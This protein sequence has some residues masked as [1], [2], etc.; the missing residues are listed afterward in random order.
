M[1]AST[2]DR[3]VDQ[4]GLSTIERQHRRGFRQFVV[5]WG[6]VFV[7]MA[8]VTSSNWMLGFNS[9]AWLSLNLLVVVAF[10][11]CAYQRYQLHRHIARYRTEQKTC[12]L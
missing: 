10:S 11:G 12:S 4:F 5:L 8:M 2:F 1:K 6:A 3:Y 9:V 7:V